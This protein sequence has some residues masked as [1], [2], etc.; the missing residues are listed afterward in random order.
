[1]TEVEGIRDT[2]LARMLGKPKDNNPVVPSVAAFSHI[3]TMH[4]QDLLNIT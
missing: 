3:L 4:L 2:D 1:M